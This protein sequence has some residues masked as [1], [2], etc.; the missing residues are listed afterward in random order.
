[1]CASAPTQLSNPDNTELHVSTTNFAASN[2]ND[3][4]KRKSRKANALKRLERCAPRQQHHLLPILALLGLPK[5]PFSS[6]I[7]ET[8][9]L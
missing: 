3:A 6:D 9:L 8:D 2:Y 1:M 7:Y 4:I 5:S